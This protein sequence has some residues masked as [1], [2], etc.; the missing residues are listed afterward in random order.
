ME[1]A[2]PQR[3]HLVT[4]LTLSRRLGVGQAFIRR[5]TSDG[6]IPHVRDGRRTL[7]DLDQA[8]AAVLRLAE[9][10]VQV[11]DAPDSRPLPDLTNRL[12]LDR[13]E[14][15]AALGLS[16]RK[17]WELTNCG[18]LPHKKIGTR[19]VYPVDALRAWLTSDD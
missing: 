13:E 16:A 9:S 10:G 6:R 5:Q 12:A 17:V 19:T 3:P 4:S 14:A 15:A 11:S 2:H 8:K 7:Y 18:E 1:T